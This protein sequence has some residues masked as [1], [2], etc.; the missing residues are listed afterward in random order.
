MSQWLHIGSAW[1]RLAKL[2]KNMTEERNHEDLNSP[3]TETVTKTETG[4]GSVTE[5]EKRLVVSKTVKHP[6]DVHVMTEIQ[7]NNKRMSYEGA[8]IAVQAFYD[9][10]Q[11]SL[12]DDDECG[13]RHPYFNGA[14]PD[15]RNWGGR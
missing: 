5:G 10:L 4:T 3:I 1:C 9:E 8:D 15:F 14:R 7:L 6:L 13:E 12:Y 2:P 11:A